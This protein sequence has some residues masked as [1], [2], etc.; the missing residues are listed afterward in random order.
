MGG[1]VLSV[2]VNTKEVATCKQPLHTCMISSIRGE[3]ASREHKRFWGRILGR[4]WDKS[5]KSFPP[6][7]S[8]S[9]L[10]T[11]LNPPSPS[12]GDFKLVCNLSILYGNLKSENS[13]DY[14]HAETSTKLTFMNSA[15]GQ[16]RIFA[17]GTIQ[18]TLFLSSIYTACTPLKI[19]SAVFFHALLNP[20]SW[21]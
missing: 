20:N 18:C 11:D 9:P 7:Y 4:N 10:L 14:A 8:Q 21:T 19:T 16:G 15:S 3:Q 13:Q 5:L 12:K 6:R 1:S 2:T 17:V